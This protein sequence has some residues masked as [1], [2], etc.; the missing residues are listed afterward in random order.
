MDSLRLLGAVGARILSEELNLAMAHPEAGTARFLLDRLHKDQTV[1]IVEAVLKDG[2][3]A[4]KVFVAVPT[5]IAEGSSLPAG[6]ITNSRAV[7]F[8]NRLAPEG[9]PALLLVNTDDDQGVSLQDMT[10]IGTKMLT[11]RIDLWVDIAATGLPLPDIDHEIWKAAL[12]GLTDAHSFTVGQL[13]KYIASVAARI[14]DEGEPLQA[15]LGYCLPILQIP[16]DSTLAVAERQQRH[17]SAWK[18]KFDQLVHDRAPL[19]RKQTKTRQLLERE[20][21]TGQFRKVKDDIDP[22]HWPVIEAFIESPQTWNQTAQALAELEWDT[23][24]I[25]QLFTGLK[26]KKVSLAQ[27]TLEFYRDKDESL[28]D[29]ADREYLELLGEQTKKQPGDDDRAFYENH[30]SLLSEKPALKAKWD[31]FIFGVSIECVD[32][33]VGLLTALHRLKS[34]VPAWSGKKTLRI[35][36]NARG[37]TQHLAVNADVATL[38]CLRYRGLQNLFGSNVDWNLDPLFDYESFLER[39]RGQRRYQRNESTARAA[40]KIR[41]DVRLKIGDD[42]ADEHVV[43]VDYIGRPDAVSASL[44]DDLQRLCQKTFAE[45]SVQRVR[46]SKKGQAQRIALEESGSFEAAY[47]LDAGSFVP[48]VRDIK[49]FDMSWRAALER[50]G[51]RVKDSEIEA[52]SNAWSAFESQYRQAIQDYRSQGVDASSLLEQ[53]RAY[54]T[55]LQQLEPHSRDDLIR[56][57]LLAP[58]LRLGVVMVEDE[59][60]AAIITPWNPMRLAAIATKSRSVGNLFKHLLESDTIEVGDERL[61]F[62]ELAQEIRHPFYPEIAVGYAGTDPMLLVVTD[63]LDDYSLAEL[64]VNASGIAKTNEDPAEGAQRVRDIVSRYLDLQPHENASLSVALFE[65]DSAGL[66]LAA[67]GALTTLQE[68]EVHCNVT[69]RH[70]DR[71]ALQRVYNDLLEQSEVDPDALVASETSRNFMAKLRVGI[72]IEPPGRVNES[73]CRQVDIAYLQDV[74]ARRARIQWRQTPTEDPSATLSTHVPPR[75]AYKAPTTSESATRYLTCPEQP[76]EGWAYVSAV[77]A[78]VERQ[79]SAR[80]HRRLPVRTISLNDGAIKQA[81]DD[82]HNLAEWVVNYDDLLDPEQLRHQNVQVIRYQK[83]RS[84]GRNIIVSSTARSRVLEV[85]LRRR[86]QELGLHVAKDQLDTLVSTLISHA[87]LISGEIVLRA[88]KRGIAAGEMIGVVLSSALVREELGAKPTACFFLDDYAS[89][90]GQKEAGIADLIFISFDPNGPGRVRVVVTEAKYVGSAGASDACK[91]S[92]RQVE[93]TVARINDALFENPGRLD[94]DLWL[95]RLA[96]LLL[97]AVKSP[98]DERLF[99]E[100][101]RL[102]REGTVEFDLRGYSHV[103]VTDEMH[104]VT[105]EQEPLPKKCGPHS[106]QETFSM[107]HTRELLKQLA[108]SEPL[109]VIRE[110]VGVERPWESRTWRAPAARALWMVPARPSESTRHVKTQEPVTLRLNAPKIFAKAVEPRA[111]VAESE[112]EPAEWQGRSR[113]EEISPRT[114]DGLFASKVSAATKDDDSEKWLE[115]TSKA[116]QRALVGWGFQAKVLGTR[117]TPNAGLVRLLGS[118]RLELKDVENNRQ[119]LLTTHSLNVLSVTPR[120]GEIIVA[121]ERRNRQIVSLWDVWKRSP[122]RRGDDMNVSFIVGIREL[123]G[124]TLFL[125]LGEGFNGQPSHAPHTLIAG[126]TGSGKSILIQNLIVDIAVTN[127]PALAKIFCIDPKMGVDYVALE[128]LPHLG[129]DVIVDQ[130][131]AITVLEYLVGEMNTRYKQFAQTKVPNLRAFNDRAMGTNRLPAIFLVHDEF[132]EWML[133]DSYKDAVSS[134][135][136]RLGVKARAAGIYLFFAAQRPDKDVLP[137]QLRDNLGNR[138][139]LR[140]E[141][142]GTSEIALGQK[143]AERL[144]GKGHCAARLQNESDLIYIQVPWLNAADVG[145]IVRMLKD[146]P[147]SP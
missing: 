106:L 36:W 61:F 63:S 14:R 125:N 22:R 116:L 92:R 117:L 55:L 27:E 101:R 135:V 104:C 131:R 50:C 144:L 65:C 38:F 19:L 124:E 42:A 112:P 58:L 72:H 41:L 114:L 39:I 44:P 115:T 122:K 139:I 32:L 13:A 84:N 78:V 77:G 8:R 108:C 33:L 67:V 99:D 81:F 110:S 80:G 93:A 15:T 89:W 69:L 29:R 49:T 24:K 85:L 145:D 30:R 143:G 98:R 9:Q 127:S 6:V 140:V 21:L 11:D 113:L 25:D 136:K 91:T 76:E 120:P 119:R 118:D 134:T 5:A 83:D 57:E 71:R 37:R 87:I 88:S 79:P 28:L 96:D 75:W 16:R 123:D 46:T 20:E 31:R 62:Q 7:H 133:T 130:S 1:A 54:A 128:G 126:T 60:S 95:S 109:F 132:A 35:E 100:V 94:R 26:T 105:S 142:E 121:I 47:G 23:D 107:S 3:L 103:F 129:E 64:P 74:V 2:L 86:L 68:S 97:D 53:A 52:L 90:L 43:Q 70:R 34:Q 66:P 73:D 59:P 137:P 102:I 56:R 146:A 45:L 40:L 18:R 4:S 17:R 51:H 141:G 82:A 12:R 147:G 10:R 111:V 48:A 138:L